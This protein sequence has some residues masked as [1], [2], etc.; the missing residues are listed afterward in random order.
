MS[1]SRRQIIAS[2]PGA[3]LLALA[4]QHFPAAA[5][6]VPPGE[7][8]AP[9]LPVIGSALR[10]P[11]VTLFDGIVYTQRQ[12]EGQVLLLYWWASWC[13][14][15]AMQNPDV[16]KLWLAQKDR[17]LH[18]LALSV[19]RQRDDATS[20][21]QKK[22]YT[23]PAAWVTPDIARALPKPKGLPV[24]VMRGRDGRVLQAEKG[25]LFPEDV[26]QLARWL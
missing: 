13:P 6:Q 16:Q 26:E 22:G 18:M 2:L 9:A 21:L 25:Q 14:F 19:D 8:N 11:D 3:G 20:Y 17:G 23:F 15:C 1:L 24:T 4:A 12:A 5:Q 10:L 7:A